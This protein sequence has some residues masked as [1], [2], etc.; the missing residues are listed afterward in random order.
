MSFIGR[1]R[2]ALPTPARLK[3]IPGFGWLG[4]FLARRPWLLAISRRR[5]ARGIGV[6]LA[7]GVIPLPTQ[8][9]M[10]ALCAVPFR[11]NVGAAVAATWITNP[12][13]A[14][15]IWALSGWFGSFLVETSI[16]E[17]WEMTQAAAAELDEILPWWD[18]AREWVLAIGKPVLVGL[19]IT[20][21]VL[22]FTAWGLVSA[23]WAFE[24]R[25]RRGLRLRARSVAAL[26]QPQ[27]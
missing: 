18:V 5:V 27:N 23:L 3:Q 16:A 1:I 25:R 26:R 17:A 14:G 7:V 21:L 6:G 12:L 9:L 20:G 2:R 10:A 4:N 22:G 24:V 19:P 8:M 11:A 15:P 13:T